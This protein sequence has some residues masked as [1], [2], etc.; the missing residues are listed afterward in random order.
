MYGIRELT[1]G[2]VKDIL[3]YQNPVPGVYLVYENNLPVYIGRSRTLAQRIGT[4]LRSNQKNQATLTY[5]LLKTFPD[6]FKD[7]N[8]ARDY[9]FDNF[10]IKILPLE[11]EYQRALFQIYISMKLN[12]K[13]NSFLET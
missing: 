7:M 8:A 4:D 3:N 6:K 9:F 12:A 2:F 1:K 10:S 11:N 5:Q 13:Y